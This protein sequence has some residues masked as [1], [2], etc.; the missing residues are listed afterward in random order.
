MTSFVYYTATTANGFIADEDNSLDW[1]FAVPGADAGQAADG[2]AAF[3]VQVMGST[4]YR[5]LIEHEDVIAQPE[6]WATFFGE[7]PTVVFSS[8]ELPVP[9]GAA[10]EVVAGSVAA[11]ADHLVALAAGKDVWIV[12]GGDL[13]G[14]FLDAGLLDRIEI[15]VAPAF[16]SGGA[17]L[18]P[19]T[20]GADRLRLSAVEPLGPFAR[21]VFDVIETA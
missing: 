17:P 16:L 1:L 9:A 19:R 7:M 2:T 11:A 8:Q 3:G 21:L 13:A 20:V 12:G 15:T 5:W 14:Q 10:L 6:K 18:L 4:T